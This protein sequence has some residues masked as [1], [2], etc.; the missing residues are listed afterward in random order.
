MFFTLSDLKGINNLNFT[1]GNMIFIHY[2]NCFIT[3]QANP[4]D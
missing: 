3:N 1:V 4:L 2:A